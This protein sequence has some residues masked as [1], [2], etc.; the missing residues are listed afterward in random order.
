[1]S[2]TCPR[3]MAFPAWSRS[4]GSDL[5]H[6]GVDVKEVSKENLAA[7]EKG[8][9]NLERH[10]ENVSKVYGIPCVV[11]INR[12]RS[13]PRRRRREGGEQGEPRGAGEGHRQSRAPCRERVQG[14]WHSL[15]G[16]DQSVQICTTA[17]ST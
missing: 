14:V 7:L 6:G 9:V 2:R 5:Y 1:M 10:V 15:R 16:L 3:C 12:F 17:A 4:I 11:S 8:I 13:V